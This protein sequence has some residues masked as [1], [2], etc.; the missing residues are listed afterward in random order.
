MALAIARQLA[1]AM[2]G[3]LT[4]R[5]TLGEGST[6]TLELP[7]IGLPAAALD[8]SSVSRVAGQVA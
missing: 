7:R 4:A 2:G 5:S 8:A 3:A 1:S 6:F